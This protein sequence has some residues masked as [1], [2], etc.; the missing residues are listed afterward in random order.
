MANLP[1]P[2][3]FIVPIEVLCSSTMRVMLVRLISAATR[4]NRTGKTLPIAPRR[5]AFSP[6]PL[7]STSVLLSYTYH[8]GSLISE[9]S[10]FASAIFFSP[11][12]ISSSDLRSPSPYSSSASFS[13]A[14]PSFISASPSFIFLS[15]FSISFQ[16]SSILACPDFSFFAAFFNSFSPLSSSFFAFSSSF[17]AAESFFCAFSTSETAMPYP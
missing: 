15:C 12:A 6:N 5:S 17:R 3:A 11:S 2:S 16:P 9:S 7:Y 13:F 1:Y 14:S 4:K 10:S 8:F